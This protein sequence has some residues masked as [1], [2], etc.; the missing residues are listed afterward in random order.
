MLPKHVA[1]EIALHGVSCLRR[2]VSFRAWD[3]LHEHSTY[4]TVNWGNQENKPSSPTSES[5]CSHCT[6][7]RLSQSHRFSTPKSLYQGSSQ[8]QV[9]VWASITENVDAVLRSVKG[10]LLKPFW[11]CC[12]LVE[13]LSRNMFLQY[14]HLEKDKKLSALFSW[15]GYL[16]LSNCPGSF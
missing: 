16:S 3:R 2:P 5:E 6:S 15:Y 14:Y 12:T 7:L 1:G 11:I 9:G 10:F 4:N 8:T 13:N